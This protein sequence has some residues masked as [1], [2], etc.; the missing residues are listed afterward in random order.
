MPDVSFDDDDLDDLLLNLDDSP[1]RPPVSAPETAPEPPAPEVQAAPESPMSSEDDDFEFEFE[2]EPRDGVAAIIK[3]WMQYHKFTLVQT[4]DEVRQIVDDALAHGRC[5]LDLETEGLDNRI[6]YGPVGQ[7]RHQRISEDEVEEVPRTRHQIVGYCISVRG[8]G[9]YIP[10]RHKYDARVEERNPNVPVEEVNEQIK[11]LCVASQPILSEEGLAEDPYAS[12]KWVEPPRVVIYFWN[13]K[14]DQEFLFPI[15]GID[16]WHPDS[17]EDGYLAAYVYYTD[18]QRLGLKNK[19][20][21]RASINGHPYEMIETKELFPKGTKKVEID[22]PSLYPE[23]DSNVTRYGCSDAICTEILCEQDENVEWD[24]VGNVTE[25]SYKNVLTPT[26][27]NKRFR[28]TYRMEKQTAQGVRVMERTRTLLDRGATQELLKEAQEERDEILNSIVRVAEGK[29]FQD[30]NPGSPNQL[31]EFLFGSSGLDLAK[32]PEKLEKSGLYKTDA[33]TLE[34]IVDSDPDAPKILRDI[35]KFRQVDKVIGTYLVKL[36]DNTDEQDQL[37]FQFK[38]TGAATGRFTAPQGPAEHGFAGVP[39][40]GI[41]AKTDP[42]RPRCANS[43]RRLFISHPGYTLIKIDYA[44]QE[45]RVVTNITREPL[46][47]NEFRNGSGDLHTLTAQAFFGPHIT[48][49]DKTERTMGKIAN[50][51]LIYGGGVQAIQRATKCNQHEAARKKKAFDASVPVFAKWVKGQ[52]AFVKK[53]LGVFTG[54]GRFIRI[55]DANIQVGDKTDRD[56]EVVDEK[57]ARKIRAGCER[58]STNYPIQGSGADILKIVF[59]RLVKE[60]HRRGWLRNGGD[61]SVRMLM[62]VH[63]EVVFEVRDDRVPEALPV[64]IEIMQSPSD[65]PKWEIP[66]IV[67]PLLGKHW[68]GK[69]DWLEIQAGKGKLPDWLVPHFE[70]YEKNGPGSSPKIVYQQRDPL[71]APAPPAPAEPTLEAPE[72]P[73]AK[74]PSSAAPEAAKAP[75]PSTA[76]PAPKAAPTSQTPSKKSFEV[77]IFALPPQFLTRQSLRIVMKIIVGTQ[78]IGSDPV[79]EKVYKWLR[80]VDP[81]GKVLVPSSMNIRVDPEA[82]SKGLQDHNLGSGAYDLID[83]ALEF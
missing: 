20:P 78:P 11:R 18:D 35:V 46:W 65:L 44:G 10:I 34:K 14:F 19:A 64:L 38:Q 67:E 51:S 50:F 7:T 8:H 76:T 13:S 17:F 82:F 80:V 2:T 55:P 4:V 22:F 12:T 40:H 6:D 48:K 25:R 53:H 23:A 31:S 73:R 61:D 5:S 57:Q 43:L 32:K 27:E 9:Y 62:T 81:E 26:L 74:E 71:P 21:D 39:I 58:K 33:D 15:T 16:F 56:V 77:A 49:A 1:V 79:D 59:I 68:G 3:P 47:L 36:L 60:L 24:L 45:L 66:L 41:P 52:H 75:E 70:A 28:A 63:D 69:Y 72:P 54:F 42:N 29:G 37:R 30:F 83:G